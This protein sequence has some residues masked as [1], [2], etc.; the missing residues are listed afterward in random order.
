M[1]IQDTMRQIE[2]ELADTLAEQ[3]LECRLVGEQGGY[4][5]IFFQRPGPGSF[6]S[7]VNLMFLPDGSWDAAH[8]EF[9]GNYPIPLKGSDW[10]YYE[11]G[12]PR[13]DKNFSASYALAQVKEVLESGDELYPSTEDAPFVANEGFIWEEL[14]SELELFEV[15]EFEIAKDDSGRESFSFEF[16]GKGVAVWSPVEPDWRFEIWIDDAIRLMPETTSDS[17][18]LDLFR[19]VLDRIPKQFR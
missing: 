15:R 6:R 1:T 18:L 13:Y 2:H 3:K 8:L 11:W 12:V 16:D 9:R 7:Q 19:D 14:L 5:Y 4:Q 10:I 17:D